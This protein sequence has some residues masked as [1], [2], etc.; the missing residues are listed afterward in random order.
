MDRGEFVEW[1]AHPSTAAHFHKAGLEVTKEDLVYFFDIL[2]VDASQV[3]SADEFVNGLARA[4]ESLGVKHMLQLEHK[5]ARIERK[6]VMT[7]KEVDEIGASTA[8]MMDVTPMDI[9]SEQIAHTA[10]QLPSLLKDQATALQ[11]LSDLRVQVSRLQVPK[12]P[13]ALVAS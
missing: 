13:R 5:V 8:H 2:D 4:Q 10:S 6:L 1:A 11:G 3:L 12:S 7:A 9:A